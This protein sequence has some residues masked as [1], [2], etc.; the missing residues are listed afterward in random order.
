M[1]GSFYL[2]KGI[3]VLPAHFPEHLV[4]YLVIRSAGHHV[5]YLLLCFQIGQSLVNGRQ[6]HMRN[7]W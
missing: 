3:I 4:I 7:F 6:H 2:G 1:S 5:C